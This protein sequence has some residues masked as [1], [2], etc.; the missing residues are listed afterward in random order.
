MKIDPEN[1]QWAERDW[2]VL[3]KG[4]ATVALY[5]TLGPEGIFFRQS[6]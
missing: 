3:S 2:L 5:P 6:G 4:H 1:P